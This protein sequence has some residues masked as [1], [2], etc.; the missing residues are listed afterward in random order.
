MKKLALILSSLILAAGVAV[1][2]GSANDG[3]AAEYTRGVLTESTYASEWAGIAFTADDG[4]EFLTDEE[5]ASLMG[6]GADIMYGENADQALDWAEMTVTYEMMATN[7]ADSSNVI[8]M[9]EKIPESYTVDMY[10]DAMKQQLAGTEVT[11]AEESVEEITFLGQTYTD[12]SHTMQLPDL[13]VRQSMYLRKIGDRML[14]ICFSYGDASQLDA[15]SA[16]FSAA[17]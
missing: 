13:E 8:V 17:K 5:I 10:I 12:F 15:L 6:I 1:S 2:C 4:M 14:A 3:A 7:P 9:T 11:L 16:C